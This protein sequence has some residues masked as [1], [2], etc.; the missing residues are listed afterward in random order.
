[1]MTTKM[2]GQSTLTVLLKGDD[3]VEMLTAVDGSETQTGLSPLVA[4][5]SEGR[6]LVECRMEPRGPMASLAAELATGGVEQEGPPADI[7]ILSLA[8][9]VFADE[10]NSSPSFSEAASSVIEAYQKA[11]CHVLI[12]NAS[13]IDPTMIVSNYHGIAEPFTR[14]AQRLDLALLELSISAGISIVDV[15]RILAEMGAEQH[16][17]GPLSYSPEARQALRAEVVRIIEDYGFFE[18]RPVMAQ[19]GRRGKEAS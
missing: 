13:T 14:K 9:D 1:M 6:T 2:G 3:L 11:G 12:M 19:V 7:V 4:E 17:V 18:A 5:A 16:V 8:P 10:V 15:D